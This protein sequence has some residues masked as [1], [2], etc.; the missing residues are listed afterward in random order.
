MG[1]GCRKKAQRRSQVIKVSGPRQ[2]NNTAPATNARAV[3][4][5]PLRA[6]TNKDG[7]LNQG[8]MSAEKRRVQALRRNEILKKLG[9]R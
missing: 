6:Q 8:G 1:C 2:P 7:G 3:G 9:K 5:T 4:G